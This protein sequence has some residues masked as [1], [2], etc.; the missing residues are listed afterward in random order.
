MTVRGVENQTGTAWK[1]ERGLCGRTSARLDVRPYGETCAGWVGEWACC[2][3]ISG[4]PRCLKNACLARRGHHRRQKQKRAARHLGLPTTMSIVRPKLPSVLP[5]QPALQDGTYI[6]SCLGR[7]MPCYRIV[8]STTKD[9]INTGLARATN[10]VECVERLS[11]WY[12]TL[13]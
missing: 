9:E 12:M 11:Q 3:E 4:G 10:P 1:S 13:Y 6:R 5:S 7:Y 8:D 2:E